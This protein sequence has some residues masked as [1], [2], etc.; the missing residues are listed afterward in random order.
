[1]AVGHPPQLDFTVSAVAERRELHSNVV[2]YICMCW[3]LPCFV[4]FG[5]AVDRFY[6]LFLSPF[7]LFFSRVHGV[8][9]SSLQ[10]G[11]KEVVQ[12]APIEVNVIGHALQR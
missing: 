9:L 11:L 6:A 5:T 4:A 3:L 10:A 7:L 2:S 12:A 8:D 1:M